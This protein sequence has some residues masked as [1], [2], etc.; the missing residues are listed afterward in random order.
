MVVHLFRQQRHLAHE[1]PGL[2]EGAEMVG[3]ADRVAIL[4]FAP[5]GELPDGGAARQAMQPFGHILPRHSGC[6]LRE[7]AARSRDIKRVFAPW[8]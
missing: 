5:A 2:A 4:D 8:R 1:A 7:L 3:L 6:L